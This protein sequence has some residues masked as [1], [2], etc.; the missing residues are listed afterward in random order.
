M[1]FSRSHFATIIRYIGISFITGAI[2]HG[3]FSGTRSLITGIIGIVC[4]TIGTLMEE[5]TSNGWKAIISGAILA[6]GIGAVTGGLQHFPDSPEQS[7]WILPVGFVLSLIFYAL[8]HG[9]KFGKKEYTYA[10]ISLVSVLA[11][12]VG[13]YAL[14]EN[15]DITAH[16]H[17][18]QATT[19]PIE[20]NTGS[21]SIQIPVDPESIPD[22][23]N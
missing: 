15:M 2:S 13:I 16:G 17:D 23:H 22:H 21:A 18:E 9:Y 20:A 1:T 7:L 14:I 3:F 19:A 11:I 10:G 4:F 8:V 5:D 12:S 6:V